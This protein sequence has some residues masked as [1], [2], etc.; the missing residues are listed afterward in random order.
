MQ[1]HVVMRPRPNLVAAKKQPKRQF[2]T[3]HQLLLQQQQKNKKAKLLGSDQKWPQGTRKSPR[4]NKLVESND[5]PLTSKP[6]T[7]KRKLD[8][9]KQHEDETMGENEVESAKIILPPPPPLTEYERQR[10]IRVQMNNEVLSALKLP[11]L[12]AGLVKKDKRRKS[13]EKAQDGSENY[14]PGHDALSDGSVTPPK[15][16]KKTNNKKL[17]MGRRPTTGSRATTRA[18]SAANPANQDT[19][20]KE[21]TCPP[22]PVI[23]P[24]PIADLPQP[25][26]GKGSMASFWAMRK[27]QKEE[28][29][30]EKAKKEKAQQIIEKEIAAASASAS[31]KVVEE[32]IMPDIEEDDVEVAVPQRMR[33]KTRMDK[34]HTRSF[35][36][37]IVIEMNDDFQPIA[38]N[39]KVLSE[40]SSFLG[41]LAK[42]CVPLTYVTWRHVPKNLRQTMWNYVKARYV[43]PDELESWV[44]ETIHSSW[45]TYKSRTKAGHFTAYENDEM[46]LENRPDDIPLETFK[47]LLDYWNDESIQEKARKNA[48]ARKHYVDTHTLGPKSLAQYRYKMKKVPGECEPCDAK[49]FIDTRKRDAKREYKIST[50][51]IEKK[52]ETITK[53]LSTGD[54]ASDELGAKHGLNWLK[55]RCVK[56]A[57]MSN[58]NAPTETYVKDLTTK[59][60]EG[61]AA[62]LE[63]KVKK[64]E[65]EFQ[66]KVKQVEAGVDQKVQQNLAFVFKKLA[67]ANPDIKIDIQELCTTVGSDNDDGTPMTGGVSF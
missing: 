9:S 34:V 51:K 28:A 31:K 30:K 26:D 60:K 15:E 22:V 37:R 11:T 20:K 56:P 64:V 29:E 2:T 13:N 17:L 32:N 46:R 40:L 44:I 45:K 48:N 59:I 19:S 43:I 66:D 14:D 8:L 38:E 55:G 5:K 1:P 47:M 39:D 42:R 35:D 53:R 4:V 52:I 27:R 54:A 63:E 16:K 24:D 67:Q 12:A 65:S 41:T 33:G 61:F 18:T 62:E 50:E 23:S 36:K 49:I 21:D 7:A 3:A 25:D 6:M 10:A 58:S 57:N